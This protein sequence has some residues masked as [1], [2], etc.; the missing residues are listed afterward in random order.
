MTI[1]PIADLSDYVGDHIRYKK[2]DNGIHYIIFMQP[3]RQAIDEWTRQTWRFF[4]TLRDDETPVPI[5]IDF[6]QLPDGRVPPLQYGAQQGKLIEAHPNYRAM[7]T[8]LIFNKQSMMQA[9][10]E[11][12]IRVFERRNPIRFF[13]VAELEAGMAWLLQG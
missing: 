4:D 2:L 11:G 8:I 1:P 5:L 12:L 7:R 3:T 6:T 10:I 13:T 9:M